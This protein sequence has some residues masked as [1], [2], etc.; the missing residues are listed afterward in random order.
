[1]GGATLRGA[2]VMVAAGVLLQAAPAL[3]SDDVRIRV[4]SNRPDL[5]SG[6]DAL[7]Q[8]LA[9]SGQSLSGVKVDVD[10]RDVTAAFAPRPDG[11]FE[12]LVTGLKDGD[13]VL[14]ARA[15]DGSAARITI[16][17]HPI[18]GPVFAG[19]QVQPW[20]CRTEDEG[21]G[22]ALDAQCDAATK[23]ELVYRSTDPSKSGFQP[24]DPAN[25]PSDVA[26]TTT[27]QGVKVPYVVRVERGTIDRSFYAIAVLY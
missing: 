17:N 5:V 7:V 11:R 8:V 10:G 14:T 21:F 16:T 18:G 24:Y 13:N 20:F 12:G 15:A 22:K 9:P 25:P 4:L 6:D 26:E 23:Y 2:L 19:P 1:M 27:D 3:A